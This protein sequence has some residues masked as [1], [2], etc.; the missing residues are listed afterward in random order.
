MMSKT[1]L[2]FIVF[3]EILREISCS[4]SAECYPLFTNMLFSS[5][6]FFEYMWAPFIVNKLVYCWV[7]PGH[8]IIFD[9]LSHEH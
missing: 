5:S 7:F 4:V 8:K 6:L 3:S 1:F 9:K 2:A